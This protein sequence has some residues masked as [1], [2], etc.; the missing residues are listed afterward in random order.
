VAGEV[1]GIDATPAMIAVARREAA[2]RANVRFAVGDVTALEFPDGAFDGAVTRF[3]LHHI[4]VPGRVVAELA[5]VVRPGGSVV[6]ADHVL[7]DDA[8]AAAWA[9]EVER[10]RDPSHWAALPL[11]RLRAL[12]ERAGLA[13][14]EERLVPLALGYEDWLARGGGPCALVERALAERP[15]GAECLRVADGVLHLRLWLGRWRR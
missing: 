6:V 3:S 1:V 15:G 12:G 13:L 9:T 2:G 8:D 4:P 7:D 14:E 11:R 5:R 10:L